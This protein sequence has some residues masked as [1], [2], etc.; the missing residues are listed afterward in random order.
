MYSKWMNVISKVEL[1]KDIEKDELNKILI[2]LSNNIKTYKKKEQ[3]ATLNDDFSA[4][5]V[6][7]E[8]EVAII[9]E[10]LAGDRTNIT[11]LYKGNTFGELGAFASDKRSATVIAG[12]ECTIFFL[13][14]SKIIEVCPN[15]C[16]GHKV[17]IENMLKSVSKKALT[18][19]NKIDFLALKTIRKKVSAYLLEQHYINNSLSFKIPLNRNELADYLIVSRPSLSRELIKMQE[20]GI[21]DFQRKEFNIL[22][23]DVLKS[24]LK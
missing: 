3:I 2:C 10:T 7:L 6:I 21:L 24:C 20:E 22:N 9:Q 18:F 13:P 19:N 14:S 16:L 17:L 15:L 4:V 8:G 12:T 5:G 23:L 1:F 11:K